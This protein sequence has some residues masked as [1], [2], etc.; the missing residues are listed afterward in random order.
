MPQCHS[1]RS[2]DACMSR[3]YCYCRPHRQRQQ[4]TTCLFG[5]LRVRR[6][7]GAERISHQF[8]LR[9][10]IVCIGIAGYRSERRGTGHGTTVDKSC[11]IREA[12]LGRVAIWGADTSLRRR[13]SNASIIVL[14]LDLVTYNASNPA[15]QHSSHLLRR[16]NRETTLCRRYLH[17]RRR[18]SNT[19]TLK[20]IA[21][22]VIRMILSSRRHGRSMPYFVVSVMIPISRQYYRA[23]SSRSSRGQWYWLL[24]L[25]LLINMNNVEAD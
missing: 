2:I 6:K 13:G 19:T 22:I 15:T 16:F 10:L 9:I 25:L 14:H 23:S 17:R 5:R 1:P 21:T 4:P 20:E 12:F 7:P 3:M 11:P 24:L 18:P 8:L